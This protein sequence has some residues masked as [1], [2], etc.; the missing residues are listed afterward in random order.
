MSQDVI[1]HKISPGQAEE[2][3]SLQPW[4]IESYA[5][6][7]MDELFEDVDQILQGGAAASTDL[8]SPEYVSI[9]P[10]PLSSI[11]LP[12]ALPVP[13]GLA[14]AQP[15][16]TL[17][18]GATARASEGENDRRSGYLL[19]KLLLTV[20]CLSLFLTGLLGLASQGKLNWLPFI[21]ALGPQPGPVTSTS[22]HN[23]QVALDG[24]FISY[25]QR[26][27]ELIDQTTVASQ[28]TALQVKSVPEV[29]QVSNLPTVPIPADLNG[30]RMPKVLERVYIP[31]YQQPQLA[32]NL[33]SLSTASVQPPV[34]FPAAPPVAV[35]PPA[36][37]V[38]HTLVG[39]M[40]L[41]KRSAA[42][43]EFNGTAQRIAIGE[44]IGAS[45]WT[46]VK[47]TSQEAVIRRNGEIRSIY[48]G[49]KF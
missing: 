2:P 45:G 3:L 18:I 8:I 7:L 36:P 12:P 31:I 11:V 19:D 37:A 24:Q 35:A 15:E 42:L 17:N 43:F 1:T 49:Q 38:I 5:D 29:S 23:P 9:Q 22:S 46:L 47:V 40:E 4:S 44:S 20:A 39:I 33:P 6:N 16:S 26:S 14:L 13:G 25:M 41:G 27:L 30:N 48:I 32:S 21:A 10:L 28:S 34:S